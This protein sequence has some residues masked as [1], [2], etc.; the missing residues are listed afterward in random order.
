MGD[1]KKELEDVGF[2]GISS[3]LPD[4]LL[5]SATSP[6]PAGAAQV[7]AGNSRNDSRP[8][9]S[10]PARPTQASPAPSRATPPPWHMEAS[11]PLPS[12][13]QSNVAWV[14]ITIGLAV[15]AVVLLLAQAAHQSETQRTAQSA[16]QTQ[17]EDTD[18]GSQAL[19]ADTESSENPPGVALD[20]DSQSQSDVTHAATASGPDDSTREVPP[21]GTDKILSVPEIRYCLAEKQRLIGVKSA[22]DSYS[23]TEV[24]QLNAMVDDYNNRCGSFRYASGAL[25]TAREYVTQHRD[26]L[27]AEGRAW[28]LRDPSKDV[29]RVATVKA[30]QRKLEELG[31]SVGTADGVIG[32]NTRDAIITFQRSMGL[33]TDGNVTDQLLTSLNGAMSANAETQGNAGI[34]KPPSAS[35]SIKPIPQLTYDEKSA[36]ETACVMA[37]TQGAASYNQCLAS[38]LQQLANG[39]REPSLAGLT[40][41][42][43]SAI[44]TACVMAGTSGAASRNRCLSK[45]LGQLANGPREPSLEGLTYGEKSAIETACVMAGTSGAASRNRCLAKQLGQLASGPREPSL[46]GLTYGEKNAIETACVMA[47]AS[48]AASHNRCLVNQLRALGRSATN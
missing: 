30:V 4:D 13:R 42:E 32:A 48:G 23:Q 17:T 20:A 15:V 36:I 28:F 2:A 40:Y 34:L 6:Q 11:S 10:Q 37:Q 31:Y 8:T 44:E 7:P 26:E 5:E 29:A 1:D 9:R 39:P 24:D 38:Q 41:G 33:V 14:W 18:L 27:L 43:K 46:E 47:G 22:V 35:A 19:L 12:P 16:A 45:Q 21:Y 3:L 25:D